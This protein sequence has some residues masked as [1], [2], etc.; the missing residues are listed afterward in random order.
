M[1]LKFLLPIVGVLC[2]NNVFAQRNFSNSEITKVVMLGS[3]NPNPSP[4]RSGSSLAIVVK[5]EVYIVDFGAGLIRQ[6][7]ALSPRYGGNIKA[8]DVKN[9][10]RAFLTHLHSDHTV[11]YPD[12]ILTPWVMGRNEPLE[13]YGPEGLNKMTTHILSAYEDDIKYRLYGT[14]PA[15]NQGW[16]VNSH[17]FYEEGVIYSDSL[18]KVEAFSVPHGSWPSAYGFRFTTPDKVIVISGDTAPSDKVVA[19]AKDADILVH[20]VYSKKGFDVRSAFWQNYHSKQ[21]T[22]TIE[23]GEMANKAKP[24]L[25]VLYHVLDWGAS[26]QEMLDEISTTYPGKV[27]VGRDLDIY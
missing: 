1:K 18:V 3:G 12:L 17:E 6:A 14:E 4:V 8:L 25:L 20:E 9:I 2:L 27:I 10:K 19:Y 5:N 23:L 21:H 24:K 7:A 15:N 11:G 16:R 13:V 26:E 22:S